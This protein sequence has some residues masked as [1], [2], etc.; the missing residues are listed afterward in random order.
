MK[1]GGAFQRWKIQSHG[2]RGFS[3]SES[4]ASE[5]EELEDAISLLIPQAHRFILEKKENIFLI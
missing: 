2:F 3:M 1:F 4:T 5:K